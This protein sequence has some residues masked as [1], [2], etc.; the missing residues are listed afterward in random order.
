MKKVLWILNKYVD[1]SNTHRYYPY[2]LSDL[3][4]E[5]RKYGIQ[6]SFVFFSDKL[7][8]NLRTK[9]NYFFKNIQNITNYPEEAQRIENDYSFTFKQAYFPEIIQVSKS[10]DHRKILVPE[11][12][13]NDLDHLVDHFLYLEDLIKKEGIDIVMS[14][15]APE[16]EM[17]FGRAICLKKGLVYLKYN[18]NFLGNSLFHQQFEFGEETLVEATQQRISHEEAKIFVEDFVKHEKLPYVEKEMC[19]SNDPFYFLRKI[20]HL[21]DYRS[22]IKRILLKPYYYLEEKIAKKLIQDK[23]VPTEKYLFFGFHM[24]TESTVGLRALPYMN[25]TSLIESIS[26]V[27]PFG[28]KLYVREHPGYKQDFSY[29]YLKRIKRMPNVSLIPTSIPIHKILRNSDGVL[30]YNATTGIE[31][32]MYG[33]PV[34]SFAPNVY[35]KHHSGALFCANL[36]ELGSKLV[37]LINTKIDQEET[38]KYMQKMFSISVPVSIMAPNFIS[39][40]D[41]LAKAKTFAEC[42]DRAINHINSRKV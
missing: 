19:P 37:Q 41:S 17:E 18:E 4:E 24:P 13:F 26:R 20:A 38:I 27:L 34:L 40:E 22:E 36:F 16:A 7:K 21:Y 39:E 35:Y 28:Y 14:D 33:K 32:L 25:Q 6:L 8:D 23:F 9:N 10:Q 12:D 5:L 42:F 2:F 11:K 29:S 3:E 30:T 15:Q 31:S 1:G